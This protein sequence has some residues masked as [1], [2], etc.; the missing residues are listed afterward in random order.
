[1]K[2]KGLQY[3]ALPFRRPTSEQ[4]E[5]LLISSLETHRWVIPKG[6]PKPGEEHEAAVREAFE[7]AGLMGAVSSSPLGS[8]EY[9]KLGRRGRPRTCRVSVHLFRVFTEADN[10]PEMDRRER[11]WLPIEHAAMH[12][13]E[14]ELRNLIFRVPSAIL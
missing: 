2:R 8:Y 13:A 5:I 3:G 10:W 6:W 7:E 4:I 11:L 9:S 1:M 14:E 12:V